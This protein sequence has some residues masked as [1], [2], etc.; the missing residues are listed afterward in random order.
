ATTD[1]TSADGTSG[2]AVEIDERLAEAK[3]ETCQPSPAARMATALFNY[4]LVGRNQG[5]RGATKAE[6]MAALMLPANGAWSPFSAVEEVFS[7]LTG[8]EGLGAL[9]VNKP[10]NSAER[11]WLTIKQTL[12]MFFNSA[13]GQIAETDALALV[14]ETAE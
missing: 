1:I 13:K 10:A 7:A 5:R 3:V 4:S 2:R 11:Y 14:R 9:E 6:L 12:R 8:D